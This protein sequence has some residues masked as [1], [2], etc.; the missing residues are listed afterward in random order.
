MDSSSSKSVEHIIPESLGNKDIILNPGIV[1]DKCNNYL[2]REVE[3]PFLGHP[4]VRL[5][6]SEKGLI[7]KKGRHPLISVR[8]GGELAEVRLIPEKK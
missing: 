4:S 8:L 3:K 6:R 1:C 5:L 7:S 2:S